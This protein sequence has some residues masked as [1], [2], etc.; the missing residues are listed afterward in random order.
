MDNRT[1]SLDEIS[2]QA[3]TCKKFYTGDISHCSDCPHG[4]DGGFF[5][6]VG[7]YT[8]SAIAIFL[9]YAWQIETL[10]GNQAQVAEEGKRSNPWVQ[11][12]CKN[13]PDLDALGKDALFCIGFRDAGKCGSCPKQNGWCIGT[14][15]AR[16]PIRIIA[17]YTE[18][19]EKEKQNKRKE[20]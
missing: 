9:R 17:K 13:F 3:R 5:N 10:R 6:C 7:S 18:E 15:F 1:L 8:P 12:S 14:A 2:K 20:D 11:L 16:E 4:K 19:L